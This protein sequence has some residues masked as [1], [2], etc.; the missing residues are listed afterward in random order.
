MRRTGVILVVLLSSCATMK[1]DQT[2]NAAACHTARQDMER[3]VEAYDLLEGSPPPDEM[4][5]VPNYLVVASP[6]MDLDAHG[7]VVA[8]P[9]SGCT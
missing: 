5:L 7:N 1:A 3:A 9:G 4:A 8:A 6:I 2:N